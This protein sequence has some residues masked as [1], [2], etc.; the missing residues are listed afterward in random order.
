MPPGLLTGRRL[1][2]LLL[3]T[4]AGLTWPIGSV[5][6]PYGFAEDASL[7]ISTSALKHSFLWIGGKNF[8]K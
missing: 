3:W 6:A 4:S 5:P 1:P 8:R 7:T 2:E